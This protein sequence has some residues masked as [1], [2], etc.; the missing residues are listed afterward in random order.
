MRQSFKPL[1]KAEEQVM[2]VLWKLEK[3]FV[4]DIIEAMPEPRPHY[5]TVSTILKILT[6]KGFA[7]Y[8]SLG[9]SNHYFP[10]IH[11]E[12]YSKGS[13]KQFVKRYFKGSFT[14]MVSF[15]VKEKD[16][17]VEQLED[18]LKELKRTDKK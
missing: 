1:T 7:S 9:K 2:Q 4:K 16:I 12:D 3:A 17:S 8:E 14:D 11:K 15:F 18:L 13:M 5:N 6:D 10:V